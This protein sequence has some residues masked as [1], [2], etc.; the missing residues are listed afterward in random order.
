M[1]RSHPDAHSPRFCRVKLGVS[2]DLLDH[3]PSWILGSAFL[4]AVSAAGEV[5]TPQSQF[6][7]Y[8]H[9]PVLLEFSGFHTGCISEGF[10]LG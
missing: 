1:K 2:K 7:V 8:G 4:S 10:L 3:F 6:L 9:N 5:I